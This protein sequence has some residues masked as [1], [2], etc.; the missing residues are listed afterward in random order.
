[1]DLDEGTSFYAVRVQA[2]SPRA[3]V[4]GTNDDRLDGFGS[5][6]YEAVIRAIGTKGMADT[7]SVRISR[8][9]EHSLRGLT[10]PRTAIYSRRDAP[11]ILDRFRCPLSCSGKM[12][13]SEAIWLGSGDEQAS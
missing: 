9:N 8:G 1:V 2:A 13:E 3:V 7:R 6:D 5:R 12:N 10:L 4:A 11:D